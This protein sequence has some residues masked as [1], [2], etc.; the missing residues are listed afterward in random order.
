MSRNIKILGTGCPNCL[1]TIKVVQ[2]VV[3]ENNIDAVVEKVDDIMDIMKYDILAT[4]AV[5]LDEEIIVKGRV[6]S[7]KEILDILTQ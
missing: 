2:E 3:Q 4:P 5:V 1:K 6:P 7:K